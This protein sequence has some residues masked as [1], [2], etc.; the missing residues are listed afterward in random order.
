M[1][2]KFLFLTSYSIKKKVKSKSFLI[3]NIILLFLFI[4][5]VNLD[6]VISLFGGDFN[7]NYTLNVVDNTGYTFDLFKINYEKARKALFEERNEVNIVLRTEDVEVL[8]NEIQDNKDLILIIDEDDTQYIRVELISKD[9][10]NS[11]EYQ[12]IAQSINTTKYQIALDHSNIDKTELDRLN[13]PIEIKRTL[14]D[15]EKNSEGETATALMGVIFPILLF[16]CFLVLLFLIQ[17]I[18]GEINEEKT[19]RSM[20]II[21][22]NVSSKTHLFSHI[23]ADNVFMIIQS[24]LLAMYGLI[25]GLVRTLT[26]SGN[27][28]SENV[29]EGASGIYTEVIDVIN[30]SGVLDNLSYII[31]ITIILML[32]A[33]FTYSFLAAV[34][35]SMSTNLEDYQQIQTPIMMICLASFYLSLMSSLFEGSHFIKI[36]S[37]VPLISCLLS[38]TLL[39]ANQITIIDSLIAILIQVVFIVIIYRYGIRIYKVGILNYSSD[40]IWRR[41]FKA[42][43]TKVRD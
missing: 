1:M 30:K 8:K 39:M 7:E 13:N 9:Y 6:S 42:A 14:L 2:K 17:I 26:G 38:P 28:I 35:A 23:I 15:K 29:T 19:T 24:A 11:T 34:L 4:L 33:F 37:Y 18:G 31:P 21:I 3:T 10:M 40:K 22:S 20:E 27:I 41:M 16:P 43:K 36:I 12:S 32:L 5:I 25:G